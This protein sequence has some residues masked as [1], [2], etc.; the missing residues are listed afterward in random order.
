M[1]GLNERLVRIEIGNF[2]RKN[3]NRGKKFTY[4]YFKGKGPSKTTIYRVMEKV[5]KNICLERKPGTGRKRKKIAGSDR[6]SLKRDTDGIVARSFR[7]L[8][9]KF[10]RAPQTIMKDLESMGVSRY[11]RKPAPLVSE[12]Q[13]KTPKS[14]I[15]P[16]AKGK[17]EALF[18]RRC[19]YG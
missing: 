12:K 17:F 4:N 5:D 2:Y 19:H 11:K 1:E 16:S 6:R 9:K 7:S 13:K 3:E 8:G 15:K 10:C 14:A 18:R